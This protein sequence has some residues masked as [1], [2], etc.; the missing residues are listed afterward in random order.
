MADDFVQSA[1]ANAAAQVAQSNA[2]NQAAGTEDPA[3]VQPTPSA[4]LVSSSRMPRKNSH[5][6]TLESSIRNSLWG[7]GSLTSPTYSPNAVKADVRRAL[8]FDPT[9]MNL[10]AAQTSLLTE[11]PDTTG[12]QSSLE[13]AYAMIGGKTP[14]SL[15]RMVMPQPAA[16]STDVAPPANIPQNNPANAVMNR[17]VATVQGLSSQKSSNS[18]TSGS[19]RIVL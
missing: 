8:K 1:V 17:N 15:S 14:K 9:N 16:Q 11:P 3:T 2:V 10:Q 19:K 4:A 18:L 6:V 7:G 5:A 12:A 13:I